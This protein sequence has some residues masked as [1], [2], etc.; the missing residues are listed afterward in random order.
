[1]GRSITRTISAQQPLLQPSC[2]PTN[3]Q[4]LQ[5]KI[6]AKRSNNT[7]AQQTKCLGLHRSSCA[8]SCHDLFRKKLSSSPSQRPSYRPPLRGP[9]VAFSI[10]SRDAETIPATSS[11]EEQVNPT[12]FTTPARLRRSGPE[13]SP[14][15]LVY[16]AK[17]LS[18]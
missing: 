10:V 12:V 4:G 15:P 9:K 5:R 16:Q 1:M 13:P 2:A 7:V 11:R 6:Q 8:F 3:V 14:L 18:F 17:T